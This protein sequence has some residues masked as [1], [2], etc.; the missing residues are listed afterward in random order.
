MLNFQFQGNRKLRDE[1]TSSRL[2]AIL[3]ELRRIRP[4][5]GRGINIQQEGNGTRISALDSFVSGGGGSGSARQPWD[6]VPR[7]DPESDP[8]NPSYLIRVRPGTITGVLPT[9]WDD[10][11]SANNEGLYYAVASVSVGTEGVSAVEISVSTDQ[12]AQP[13]AEL[14]SVSSPVEYLFGLFLEGRAYR[15]IG[16]G[17]PVLLPRVYLTKPLDEPAEP[18]ELPYEQY[19][20]VA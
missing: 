11:F 20:I 19:Y 18:G 6:L 13:T 9:N 17:S 7:I 10:E 2:N 1:L 12:A 3:T 14:W 8:E 5:A 4:V 15:V 16:T